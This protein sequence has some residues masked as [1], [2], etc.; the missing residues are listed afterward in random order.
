[1]DD[2]LK[3]LVGILILPLLEEVHNEAVEECAVAC[4]LAANESWDVMDEDT[5]GP[6][7]YAARICRTKRV[8]PCGISIYDK[9]THHEQRV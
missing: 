6:L 8:P 2:A 5:A 1:M 3:V 9:E 4:D 7:A